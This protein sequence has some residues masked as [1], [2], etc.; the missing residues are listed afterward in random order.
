[1][2]LS[3]KGTSSYANSSLEVLQYKKKH[4]LTIACILG[5]LNGINLFI[6]KVKVDFLD[7]P[8]LPLPVQSKVE[9][10]G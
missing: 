2:N 7:L 9:I 5:K 3:Q 10:L 8:S 4:R 1:M 6:D